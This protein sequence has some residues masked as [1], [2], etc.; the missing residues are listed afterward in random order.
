MTYFLKNG[1]TFQ[2]ADEANLDLHKTLPAGNYVVKES[3]MTKELYFEG[4]DGFTP[5]SRVYGAITRQRD[6]ILNTFGERANST[7]VLLSGE[8]GSGKTLLAK[9]LAMK[10]ADLDIPCIVIN[11]PYCGDKFNQLIQAVE[12]PCMVLFDEFEKVYDREQQTEILTLLD[13]VFPSKKLF[14]LTCNDKFRID[15]HMRNRPGRIYYMLDFAGLEEEFIREY[16]ADNLINKG[17]IDSICRVSSIF[18]QF[19]FDLLKALVEE[20]NRYNESP[21]EALEMLNAKPDGDDGCSYELELSVKGVVVPAD[22]LNSP[23]WHGNPLAR[24]SISIERYIPAESPDDDSKEIVYEFVPSDLKQVVNG[25]I[26]FESRVANLVFKR[27]KLST[28]NYYN[29]L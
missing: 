8:K 26:E 1:T 2:V 11:S 6:R 14:V 3:P 19:N 27:M 5:P 24:N 22:E 4:I 18:G 13:G 29:L 23:T 25:K 15:T 21:Q 17:H 28:Y 16:C 20:M 7:G 12:Q 9:M 10:A